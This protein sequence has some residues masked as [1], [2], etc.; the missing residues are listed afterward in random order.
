MIGRLLQGLGDSLISVI[1][2]EIIRVFP[3]DLITTKVS[4]FISMLYIAMIISPCW[5]A[6]FQ[7]VH[8]KI[9]SIP[10]RPTNTPNVILGFLW[11]LGLFLVLMF[12]TNLSKT[13]DLKH[14]VTEMK[15]SQLKE[16]DV[17]KDEGE[18]KQTIKSKDETIL[19]LKVLLSNKTFLIFLTINFLSC[20][21]T[22]LNFGMMVPIIGVRYYNLSQGFIA[23]LFSASSIT[24]A[25]TVFLISRVNNKHSTIYFII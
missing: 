20:Y 23:L 9:F 5:V 4:R 12:V 17:L 21:S 18:S 22:T 25:V 14:D 10:L 15:S 7:K 8:T 13:Y 6:L 2:G 1:N 3:Q 11:L 16:N 24:F 19:P